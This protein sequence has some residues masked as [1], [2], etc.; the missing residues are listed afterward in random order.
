MR[1]FFDI[2]R[3]KMT[4]DAAFRHKP[5]TAGKT[6][7]TFLL[8]YIIASLLSSVIP[9]IVDSAYI[10]TQASKIGLLDAYTAAAKAGNAE[11]ADA[12]L[13]QIFESIKTPSWLVAIELAS[14]ALAGVTAIFYCKK[15]EKR[16]L[17]SLGLRGGKGAIG[18]AFLGLGIGIVITAL[19]VG[20]AFATTSISFKFN[21]S[22]TTVFYLLIPACFISALAEELLWRGYLM[23]SLSRDSSPIRSILIMSIVY[24]VFHISFNPILI[25]NSFLFSF[26]MGVYVFKRGSIWGATFINFVWTYVTTAIFGSFLPIAGTT[27][28]ILTTVFL[29][30]DYVSGGELFGFFGGLALTL[31]IVLATCVL[32]L[33]K[34][35]K[36]EISSFTIDYFN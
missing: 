20:F 31:I 18:E 32:L 19:V 8:V 17:K 2:K 10:L 36:K 21:S 23:T 4:D 13:A 33:T 29:R 15:F 27:P 25:L 11:A 5:V 34:T 22:F 1:K 35:K 7:L 28:S 30:A 24:T 3:T 26:F 14:L 16:P 9:L 12:I 6:V